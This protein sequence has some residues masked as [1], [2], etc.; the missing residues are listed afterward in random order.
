MDM[1]KEY[2]LVPH[3]KIKHL[4]TFVINIT[5]RN[6]HM[7]S[8]FELLLILDGVGKIHM[9]GNH[10]AVKPGDAIL[11]NPNEMHEIDS[12]ESGLT[13]IILQFSRHY[14]N[15]YFPFLRN[16]CFQTPSIRPFFAPE[17]Y[18]KLVQ[19]VIR[20]ALCYLKEDKLFSLDCLQL[21]TAILQ[22]FYQ[23]LPYALFDEN[24]YQERKKRSDRVNRLSTYIDENYLYPIRL[25][26]LAMQ[27]GISTT[28]L[29]HF[30]ADNFG[31]TFQEYLNDKRLE[32]ALRL[33]E[34]AEYS[35]AALSEL[36]GFSDPK[37]LNKAFFHKF[38]YTFQEYKK[39]VKQ[40]LAK[41]ADNSQAL[42]YYYTAL[43][44]LELLN[45]FLDAF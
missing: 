13:L 21:S 36:S 39:T 4:N 43:E 5:Y 41:P 34:N 23:N 45:R 28:H 11:I 31:V 18:T 30:F 27:E 35:L 37:Y 29:S 44:S 33:A 38:G 20:L 15:E 6:F 3:S 7:H 24:T 2:E 10:I 12:R 14:L 8:D 1:R 17:E 9:K 26:D 32:Q 19:S 16:T 42:Q 40:D 25:K 22:A